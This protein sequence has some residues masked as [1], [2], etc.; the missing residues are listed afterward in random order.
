MSLSLSDTCST[1]VEDLK[2]P[3]G[4]IRTGIGFLDHM[5]DQFN[6]HA[7]I[8]VNL[9]LGDFANKDLSSDYSHNTHDQNEILVCVG[10]KLGGEFRR[11]IEESERHGPSS[12]FAC[13][14]DEALVECHL[15][16]VASSGKLS[17]FTLPPYGAYPK[18]GRKLI[19][20][21]E[22]A[23]LEQFFV[24]FAQHAHLDVSLVKIRG[25]NAHHIVESAFKALSR[26]LRNLIDGVCCDVDNEGIQCVYGLQSDN[27][28]AGIELHRQDNVSRKTKETSIS[29]DL[30]LDGGA[31]GV[32][33]SS[34]IKTLDGFF[35]T[36][37]TH[38]DMSLDLSCSGDLWIDE[39]HT[40][41]DVSIALGQCLTGALGTK[42]GLNRMWC[43]TQ[44]CGSARVQVV[45]DLSNRPCFTQNLSLARDDEEMIGDLSI[46]MF[47]HALDSLVVNARMTVHIVE[48]SRGRLDDM[49]TCTAMAFGEALKYC[50]MV[51]LRRS[52]ATAS[53][54]GTLSV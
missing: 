6:S 14:L 41:E 17:S 9:V 12:M 8:G 48:L 27:Y 30:K 34:G 25:D 11:L 13:P 53:S 1:V 3:A 47:E 35:T 42:A 51:D 45:M 31:A 54:K 23:K 22:T 33:V 38:A 18:T 52:G 36:L 15:S 16:V 10:S 26:A 20:A 49:A 43:S 21:L 37:A 32:N 39:H 29:V 19:G 28:L 50:S 40:A 5:I 44:Q 7:Q 4:P 46:E 2:K 24:A